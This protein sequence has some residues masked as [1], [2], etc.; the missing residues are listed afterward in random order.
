LEYDVNKPY[1]TNLLEDIKTAQSLEITQ[2]IWQLGQESIEFP[3]DSS[4]KQYADDL[5]ALQMLCESVRR[6]QQFDWNV[7]AVGSFLTSSK[8]KLSFNPIGFISNT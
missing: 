6:K 4:F 7:V 3:N 1:S 8:R 5:E 2:C